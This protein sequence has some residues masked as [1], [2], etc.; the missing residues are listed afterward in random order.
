MDR[1]CGG[2]NRRIFRDRG[3]QMKKLLIGLILIAITQAALASE[4]VVKVVSNDT[5]G[6]VVQ[7]VK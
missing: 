1:L 5:D 4:I 3:E 2:K 7:V 6:I